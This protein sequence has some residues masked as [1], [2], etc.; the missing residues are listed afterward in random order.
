MTH[1]PI[2]IDPRPYQADTITEMATLFRK[3]YTS[4]LIESPTGSG[5]TLMGLMASKQLA[6]E[7]VPELTG[8][9][10]SS[11]RVVWTAMRSNLLNATQRDNRLYY[12]DVHPGDGHQFCPNLSTVSMFATD[13]RH[14]R[15]G[16][17]SLILVVD[18]AHHDTTES[19]ANIYAQLRPDYCIGLSATPFRQDRNRLGFQK[20]IKK[21]GYRSLI[22]AGY[23]SAYRHWLISDDWT[24]ESVTRTYLSKDW[25]KTS[26]M[27]FLTL[28]ECEEA[29]RL[30]IAA[31]VRSTVVTGS[32]DR[33]KQIADLE[34]GDLDVV[35]SVGIL[36]EGFDFPALDTVFVRDTKSK[37]LS[38]QMSGRALRKYEVNGVQ[39]VANIVQNSTCRYPFT[40][41]A[42]ALDQLVEKP[43]GWASIKP[44]NN[45]ETEVASTLK[46]LI[47]ADLTE[48]HAASRIRFRSSSKRK[49]KD[50]TKN[51]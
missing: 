46:K 23:L 48:D 30:L 11:I 47:E 16:A 45:V 26:V 34:N 9:C 8:K 12:T 27:F 51:D 4:L 29:N 13:A 7:I 3:G 5:K 40:R 32:T 31:G 19:M 25:G 33:E 36:A 38:I 50:T 21:A 17:E 49:W 10:T 35:I 2:K 42:R 18:E 24:P 37:G 41:F 28:A 6:E 44:N 1:S 43:D 22:D 14:L 39:K 20:S 15:E